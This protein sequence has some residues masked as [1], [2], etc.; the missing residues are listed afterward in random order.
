MC[1][2][3]ADGVHLHDGMLAYVAR[4]AGPDR[5]ALVTDAIRPGLAL[6]GLLPDWARGR[7]P[8]LEPALSLRALPPLSEPHRAFEALDL[9]DRDRVRVAAEAPAAADRPHD[10]ADEHRL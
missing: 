7:N 3:I 4:T 6:Y 1:E 10:G 9:D 5:T 2:L 8:G